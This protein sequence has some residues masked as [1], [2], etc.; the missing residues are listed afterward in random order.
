MMP[1][2]L[3]LIA[4]AFGGCAAALPGYSPPRGQG[5]D[6]RPEALKPFQSGSLDNKGGYVVSDA[7]RKLTC[8][9]ITG[10]MHVIMSRLKDAP[11]R[12]QESMAT[13]AA[14]TIS[15][16]AAA[17]TPPPDI[18]TEV[19]REKAR[20]KAYNELLA[21]KKCPTLDIKAYA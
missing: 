10:S 8:G 2:L 17:S 18:A 13:K 1:R 5:S 7:E 20:L 11:N 16:P 19:A 12:P 14:Q 9:K 21:E 3:P 4:L 6:G 15:G